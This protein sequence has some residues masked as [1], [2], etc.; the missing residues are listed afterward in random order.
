MGKLAAAM[1][2]KIKGKKFGM[3]IKL[4]AQEQKEATLAAKYPFS[5]DEFKTAEMITQD[6]MTKDIKDEGDLHKYMI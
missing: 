2:K 3:E 5:M 4:T 1:E 6:Q